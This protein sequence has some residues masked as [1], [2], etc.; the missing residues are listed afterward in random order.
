MICSIHIVKKCVYDK[1]FEFHFNYSNDFI[2]SFLNTTGIGTITDFNLHQFLQHI[3]KLFRV[4]E[5]SIRDER[6]KNIIVILFK[7]IQNNMHV[8]D[9]KFI[10]FINAV[11]DN[12][13]YFYENERE[14]AIQF[15]Q[16][17]DKLIAKK[18]EIEKLKN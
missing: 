2:R 17:K 14:F 4:C 5:E 3:K 8:L 1:P 11:I 7:I 18:I 10:R 15:L 9:Y 13:T 16:L 12:I 6:K